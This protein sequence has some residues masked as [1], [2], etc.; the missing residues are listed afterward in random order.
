MGQGLERHTI[1]QLDIFKGRV[2]DPERVAETLLEYEP[3]ARRNY[4]DPADIRW[5]DR[6]IPTNPWLSNEIKDIWFHIEN[7][8]ETLTKKKVDPQ[9]DP[10]FIINNSNEQV[11][12][13]T[14][15]DSNLATVYWAK[16]APNCGDLFFYP[17]G[18]GLAGS[19]CT[20]IEPEAGAFLIFDSQLLHGVPHNVSNQPRISMSRNY[21]FVS[22]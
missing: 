1:F 10:W 2:G 17:I 9:C 15:T 21:N 8:I 18:M 7:Q 12:P 16:V 6:G 3:Q 5:Q 14:H 13:H 20:R 4:D 11:Y 22:Q 19:I